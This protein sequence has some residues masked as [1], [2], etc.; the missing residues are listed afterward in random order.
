[1]VRKALLLVVV[2]AA[3]TLLRPGLYCQTGKDTILLGDEEL[4]L[5]MPKAALLSRL[6][7]RYRLDKLEGADLWVV[8]DRSEGVAIGAVGFTDG[9]VVYVGREW[10][11]EGLSDLQAVYGVLAQF[12]REG[13]GVCMLNADHVQEPGQEGNTVWLHCGKKSVEILSLK[14]PGHLNEFVTETLGT[15]PKRE[16]R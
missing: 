5:G 7:D 2:V 15:R 3:Q 10:R 1:M 13:R 6:G 16:G 8:A 4:S 12:V 9:K 11:R 14:S